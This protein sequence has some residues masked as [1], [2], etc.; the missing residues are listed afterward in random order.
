VR[1]PPRKAQPTTGLINLRILRLGSL[2]SFVGRDGSPPSSPR[3]VKGPVAAR[4]NLPLI[5]PPDFLTQEIRGNR[6]HT[7]TRPDRQINVRFLY[8]RGRTTVRNPRCGERHPSG[9]RCGTPSGSHSPLSSSIRPAP[10]AGCLPAHLPGPAVML[11]KNQRAIAFSAHLPQHTGIKGLATNRFFTPGRANWNRYNNCRNGL[12]R[13]I[14]AR[15]AESG[16][17]F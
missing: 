2:D 13:E 3:L 17:H 10:S 15:C 1:D 4:Q 6:G 16:R 8:K 9:C 12:R 11:P 5:S 7:Q 14:R